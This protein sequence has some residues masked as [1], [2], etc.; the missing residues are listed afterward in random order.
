MTDAAPP[1]P[2]LRPTGPV[3]PAGETGLWGEAAQALAAARA[4]EAEVRE[5]AR[6]FLEQE[7]ARGHAEG[8]A[9]GAEE[10]ARLVAETAAR[11]ADHLAA[12]ERDLP[13]LV[14]G[15]VAGIVGAFEPGDRIA[16]AVR[17]ALD[18]LRP[19]AQAV[20]RVSP[21]EIEPVRA[22][23]EGPDGLPLRIEGDPSLA[24]GECTLRSAVGRVEL[25][26][27]AQL[28]ALRRGLLKVEDGPRP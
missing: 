14:H 2:R 27:E 3:V 24:P 15:L 11:A 23:L 28:R 22:A 18:R 6:E 8:R 12:L 16:R 17:H 26:V 4:H 1:A 19:D 9:A 7:R 10:A 13:A 20:L 25:G 5:W 21:G